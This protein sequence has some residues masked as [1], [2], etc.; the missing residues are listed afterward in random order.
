MHIRPFRVSDL[1]TLVDLTV[2]V[3]RP[4][5]QD[6]VHALL[7][8]EIFAHQH[9]EWEQEYRDD[10]PTLHEPTAGRFVAVG[11]IDGVVPGYVSWR[12]G[13]KPHHG[14]IYL[15]AVSSPYRGQHL[16]HQLCNFA[17][18]QMRAGGDEVVEIGTGDD[19]FHTAARARY[20]ELGFT[21]IP[22]AAYLMRI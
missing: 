9:G 5:Y 1:S 7:G 12:L 6:Y 10:I 15:L 4:F 14:Q 22:V 21:K 13:G 20:E 18:A 2:E 8:D 17:M 16:G 3:F 11:E 19:A